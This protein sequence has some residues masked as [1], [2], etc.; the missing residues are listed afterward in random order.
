MDLQQLKILYILKPFYGSV[1][2]QFAQ[3]FLQF[4]N[5]FQYSANTHSVLARFKLP[6]DVSQVT[7]SIEMLI[8]TLFKL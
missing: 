2:G 3:L 7:P 8:A 5:P 6:Y 4:Y 1:V